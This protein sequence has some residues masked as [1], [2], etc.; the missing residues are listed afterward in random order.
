MRALRFVATGLSVAVVA[1]EGLWGAYPVGAQSASEQP[2]ARNGCLTFHEVHPQITV[3]KALRTQ[4]PAGYRIYPS[5]SSKEN[6][7]LLLREIPVVRGSEVA[8]AQASFDART[9]EPVISFRFNA[10]G[11][12]KFGS[13][14]RNN[15]GRPFAIVLDDRVISAPVIREPILDGA[16]QVSGNFTIA[17]AQQLATK[18]KSGT[19]P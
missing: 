17:E 19:C 7:K 16:G 2:I 18:L 14:T 8:D 15:V 4:V 10:V 6:Q 5:A 13:F 9:T 11:A 12:R 1:I 3:Q